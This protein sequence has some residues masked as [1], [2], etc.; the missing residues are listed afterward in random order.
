MLHRPD[1]TEMDAFCAAVTAIVQV[2]R[3]ALAAAGAL[4]RVRRMKRH[5]HLLRAGEAAEWVALVVEG[6]LRE[7]FLLPDGTERTKSFVAEG[8]F[9]GSLVDLLSE[10]PSRAS[11]VAETP[12]HALLIQ[13][14]ELRAL[15]EQHA[16]WQRFGLVVKEQVLA[17]KA[18]REYELLALDAEARYAAFA[19][20]FPGIEGRVAAKHIAT[21]LGITPV[22][23]SRLRRRRVMR[24]RR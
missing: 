12:V 23:L 9:S 18:E 17:R 3:D 11:I 7:Y 4:L 19:Q 8:Q 5:E 16:T 20:L 10:A 1:E 24:A 21:Y 22:H 14:R 15:G 2:D 6:V 13:H